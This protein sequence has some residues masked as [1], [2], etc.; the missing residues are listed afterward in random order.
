MRALNR[1]NQAFPATES[2]TLHIEYP[3]AE[4]HTARAN[5]SLQTI[6]WQQQ[7][8]IEAMCAPNTIFTPEQMVWSLPGQISFVG[9]DP[10]RH[11]A[12]PQRTQGKYMTLETLCLTDHWYW[13]PMPK[14]T[15]LCWGPSH[16]HL[17]QVHTSWLKNNRA[18]SQACTD[19]VTLLLIDIMLTTR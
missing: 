18:C 16:V 12:H 5:I 3:S 10:V 11:N 13:T 2:Y 9:P 1:W 14:H 4:L 15:H 19:L 17:L 6:H 7:G 8:S